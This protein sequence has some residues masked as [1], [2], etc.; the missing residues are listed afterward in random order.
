MTYWKMVLVFGLVLLGNG[1]MLGQSPA[2]SL[3]S[4][5]VERLIE[6]A[7]WKTTWDI[8]R[9]VSTYL[10]P[11]IGFLLGALFAY[12]GVKNQIA[13]WAEDEIT[14]KA[15]EKFGVDWAVVKQLVDDK[16]KDASIKAKRLAIVNKQTGRRQDLV[17]MLD[18][19][20]FKDP[21]PSFFN[22]TDFKEKFDYNHFDLIVLDNHDSKL[23]E[24]EMRQIIGA[25]QFPYVL[26]TNSELSQEFFGEFKGTVKFAKIQENIPDYIAQS[27]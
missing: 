14:K 6:V 18:K 12:L 4:L 16:K 25:Y 24:V 7:A 22:L 11:I 27:F 10:L 8:A 9:E 3:S 15:N 19:Y 23:T 1:V 17:S 13:K 20:G 26:Y 5:Q 21:P 2:D